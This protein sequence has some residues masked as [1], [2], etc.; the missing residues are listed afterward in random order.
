MLQSTRQQSLANTPCSTVAGS[1]DEAARRPDVGSEMACRE[2]RVSCCAGTADDR[3]DAEQRS[4]LMQLLLDL[5]DKGFELSD[6]AVLSMRSW[7][8]CMDK[9]TGAKEQGSFLRRRTTWKRRRILH[10]D[11]PLQ[12]IVGAGSRGHGH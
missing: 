7:D 10:V 5:L 12:G 9:I 6:I 8:A 2:R 1:S 3:N 4:K 11:S